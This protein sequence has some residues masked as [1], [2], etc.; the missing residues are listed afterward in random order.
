MSLVQIRL[1]ELEVKVREKAKTAAE[2][3]I[4]AEAD[5]AAKQASGVSW[6]MDAEPEEEDPEDG[7]GE[8]GVNLGPASGDNSAYYLEVSAMP[9]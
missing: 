2:A 8:P 9:G 1:E 6:G 4:K 7:P 5:A 3:K